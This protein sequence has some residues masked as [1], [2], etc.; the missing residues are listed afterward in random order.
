MNIE[1][2]EMS[3]KRRFFTKRLNDAGVQHSRCGKKL[4]ELEYEQ[5]KQEWIHLQYNQIDVE[6]SENVWF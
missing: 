5:L 3:L 1:S 6:N 2:Y 4:Q